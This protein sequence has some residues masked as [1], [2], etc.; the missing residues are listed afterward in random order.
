MRIDNSRYTAFL[1]NPEKYRLTYEVNLS[2]KVTPFA[3][4]RGGYFHKLN[5]ARNKALSPVDTR[6]LLMENNASVKAKQSGDALFAA[7]RRRWDGNPD[8]KLASA[9]GRP[10]AEF[11]FDLPIPGSIHSLI[12]AMDEIVEF[13][14]ELWVGDTKTAN[15]KASETKKTSEFKLSSQ[16]IFYINAARM[17]GYPVVGMV[18]RV[19]TEHTPPQH[20]V[21]PVRKSERALQLG[22]RH[23]HQVAETIEFYRKQFGTDNPWPHPS[24]TYPCNYESYGKPACEYAQVCQMRKDEMSEDDL[25][26][27]KTR[28][29]HL[30]IM[31]GR[32]FK[33]DSSYDI[34]PAQ[35]SAAIHSQHSD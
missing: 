31:K 11:E 6:Q 35:P 7:F 30:K 16:P 29:D 24:Q 8:F 23:I 28:E 26:E 27:F 5:E 33:N 3:L 34:R 17:M 14:E 4:D 32:E 10:L 25:S 15:N 22:L 13:K 20:Y 12:G 19:V 2:P 18:Y 1:A 21:I 9:D